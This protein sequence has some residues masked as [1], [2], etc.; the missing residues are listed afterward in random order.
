MSSL[1]SQDI[2]MN[3]ISDDGVDMDDM[4]QAGAAAAGGDDEEG[5]PTIRW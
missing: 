4:P 2:S 1:S 5:V 3:D